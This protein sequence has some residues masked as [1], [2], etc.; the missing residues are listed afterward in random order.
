MNGNCYWRL[1]WIVAVGCASWIW[2]N[3]ARATDE[4][5]RSIAAVLSLDAADLRRDRA[6]VVQGTLTFQRS[7]SGV[8]QDGDDAIFV[9]ALFRHGIGGAPGE[10]TDWPVIPLGSLVEVTGIVT[11]GGYAPTIVASSIRI[12]EPGVLPSPAVA[13]LGRLFTG[14]DDN[15]RLKV[16][17]V[18]QGAAA[19]EGSGS[20]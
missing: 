16:R 12:L 9:A 4:P 13:D 18:V 10:A 11:P 7:A 15:R 5:L 3:V 17:G 20:W 6:V 14:A 19:G 8:I 1:A 2:T